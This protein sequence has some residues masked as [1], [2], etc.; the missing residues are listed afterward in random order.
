MTTDPTPMQERTPEEIADACEKAAQFYED[1]PGLAGAQ[2]DMDLYRAIAALGRAVAHAL[3]EQGWR[4]A[5]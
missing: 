3:R 4:D 5:G 1:N 2:T